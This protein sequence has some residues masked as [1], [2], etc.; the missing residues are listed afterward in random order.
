MLHTLSFR[1][2]ARRLGVVACVLLAATTAA[3]AEKWLKI[4]PDDPYSKDGSFHQF[5]VDSAFEDR[6]TGYVAARMTYRKP[7]DAANV[8]A[9]HVWAFDCKGSVYYVAGPDDPVGAKTVADWRTKP[10]SLKKPVMGGVTNSFGKKLC[11]LKGS[12]PA[13]DLP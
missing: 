7:E 4:M 6:A 1:T 8:A 9:W 13:G 10:S 5:D 12:W 2:V 11:A 3:R